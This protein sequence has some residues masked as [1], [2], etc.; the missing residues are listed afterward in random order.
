[1]FDS[2]L[3]PKFK[4]AYTLYTCVFLLCL[5]V[6][7]LVQI[8]E[9]GLISNVLDTH[10]RKSRC[11]VG[12]TDVQKSLSRDSSAKSICSKVL[13]VSDYCLPQMA[14]INNF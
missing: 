7:Y 5:Y 4:T 1:M 3:M 13:C 14:E 10:T 11:S 9:I 6:F 2:A 12:H 8:R